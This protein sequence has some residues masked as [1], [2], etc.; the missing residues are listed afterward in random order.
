[1]LARVPLPL[2][3]HNVDLA[4]AHSVSDTSHELCCIMRRSNQSVNQS[5]VGSAVVAALDPCHLKI[6]TEHCTVVV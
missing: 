3:L 5:A 6:F 1:V 2:V 4:G